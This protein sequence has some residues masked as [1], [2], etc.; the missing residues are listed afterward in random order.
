VAEVCVKS[1]GQ[2]LK[3]DKQRRPPQQALAVMEMLKRANLE[4]YARC[5]GELGFDIP[6]SSWGNN[7]YHPECLKKFLSG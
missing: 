6:I 4:F 5:G 3:R 2:V 1:A 7:K